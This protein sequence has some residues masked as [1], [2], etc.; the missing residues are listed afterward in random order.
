MTFKFLF[1]A[2][3]LQLVF[4]SLCDTLCSETTK[5]E[6]YDLILSKYTI[7]VEFKDYR[8]VFE[9][10]LFQTRVRTYYAVKKNVRIHLDSSMHI[11][12][13][14]CTF[15]FDSSTHI[16]D[17]RCSFFHLDSSAHTIDKRCTFFFDFFY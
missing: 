13:K 10:F 9:G 2:F 4:V 1:P 11:I 12:D 8:L 7:V 5:T 15:F 14:R 17:K 6:L 16:I 3:I